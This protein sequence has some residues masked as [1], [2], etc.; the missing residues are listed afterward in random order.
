M[1]QAFIPNPDNKLQVDHIDSDP[2]NNRASNLRWITKQEQEKDPCTREDA[3]KVE[4]KTD[5]KE[6][7]R[8][9]TRQIA[10]DENDYRLQNMIYPR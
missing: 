5:N 4:N 9:R 10:I 6:I 7:V 2:L 3:K 1:T 8:N